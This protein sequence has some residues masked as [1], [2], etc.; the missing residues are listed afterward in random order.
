ML[1]FLVIFVIVLF[2]SCDVT[3]QF[4]KDVEEVDINEEEE[5]EEEEELPASVLNR[6]IALKEDQVSLF[7]TFQLFGTDPETTNKFK[8]KW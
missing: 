6:V 3:L 2:F 7:H 1:R 8:F 4:Q 5:Q